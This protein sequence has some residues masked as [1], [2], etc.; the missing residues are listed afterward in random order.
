MDGGEEQHVE[1]ELTL[2][3]MKKEE[4]DLLQKEIETLKHENSALR[5]RISFHEENTKYLTNEVS[6][7]RASVEKKM[8]QLKVLKAKN[9][10]L[11]SDVGFWR[12]KYLEAY[13]RYPE[14]DFPNKNFFYSYSSFSSSSLTNLGI[15]ANI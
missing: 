2:V 5:C 11:I 3:L 8:N 4:Y 15:G 7:T 13:Q 9:A 6:F 14:L 10:N 1:P 12:G